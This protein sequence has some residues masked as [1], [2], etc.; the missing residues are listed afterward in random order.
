MD[1]PI[2]TM[3]REKADQ[4]YRTYKTHLK[5]RH[6]D[7][8]AAVMKGYKAMR[9]EMGVLDA[10]D[11]ISLGGVD[12]WG[13]P[14]LALVRAHAKE[15]WFERTRDGAVTFKEE[16]WPDPRARFSVRR[17]PA[18]TLPV[19][20]PPNYR[21]SGE[22]IVPLIPPQFIPKFGLHNYHILFEAEWL[23]RPP[24]DPILLK[25]LGGMLYAVLAQWDLTP[26]EQA[27]LK[28]RIT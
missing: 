22:A 8:L 25:H 13:R 19:E 15:V 18:G 21:S 2:M 10:Q 9:D 3:E 20:A 5:D 27:V 24:V 7:E 4:A 28:G 11:A 16:R 1:A 14:N 6:D 23:K 26:L 17:F 12:N